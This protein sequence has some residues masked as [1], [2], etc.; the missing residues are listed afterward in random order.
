MQQIVNFL[1]QLFGM[2]L[3]FLPDSPFASVDIPDYV[4]TIL[5]YANYFLPLSE[6]VVV[7]SAWTAAIAVYLV[8]SAILRLIKAIE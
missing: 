2:L 4:L 1:L 6:I 5:G 7:L 3:A 8:Y